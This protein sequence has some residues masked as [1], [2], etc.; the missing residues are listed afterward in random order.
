M[1]TSPTI[2]EE[3]LE[4]VAKA[5]CDYVADN[6][7]TNGKRFDD[8]KDTDKAFVR[9]M[10]A[11]GIAAFSSQSSDMTD[12]RERRTKIIENVLI[13][14]E[15]NSI[16]VQASELYHKLETLGAFASLEGDGGRAVRAWACIE[17]LREEEA[18]SVEILCDNPEGPPNAAVICCGD[19]TGWDERR[20]E[21][22]N[23][24]E[25]LEAAVAAHREKTVGEAK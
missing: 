2:N 7:A 22:D 3:A 17:I 12:V 4:R 14:T 21:G 11:A 15:K 19:W 24:F 25:A 20:F 5:I 23:V 13:R 8:L 18:N 6:C 1:T 10:S 16:G 9:G